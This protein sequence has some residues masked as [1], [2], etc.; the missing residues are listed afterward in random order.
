MDS[1][2]DIKIIDFGCVQV[3]GLKEIYTPVHDKVV[4]GT[5]NYIAPE[6]FDGFEGTPKSDMYSLG[7]ILYEIL[8]HGHF[9]YGKLSEAKKHKHYDYI[10][11]R[12]YKLHIPIWMDGALERAVNPNPNNRYDTFS[13]FLRDLSKPNPSLMKAHAPLIERNPLGFW[14]GLS[15][16][17]F[18]ANMILIW[19]LN[20][21][22]PL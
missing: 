2:G 9:P 19:L 20:H 13:E 7:I 12:K 18:L 1:H 6:L 21:D 11:I 8:S 14:R 15:I 3:A 17:L 4:A 22:S 10:S 5:A 16:I